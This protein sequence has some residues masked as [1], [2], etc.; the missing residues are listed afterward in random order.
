MPKKVMD[1][2]NTHFYKIVCKDLNIKNCYV[3][4][5]SNFIKRKWA[6][7]ETC[8]NENSPAYNLNIYRFIRD[9]GGFQNFDMILIDTVNCENR[10][11]A[12]K[13]EREYIESL[14][15]TL[16]R[17][18]PYISDEERIDR[19]K[20]N[21]QIYQAKEYQCECGQTV[22]LPEKSKH[23][24]TAKHLRLMREMNEPEYDYKK[25]IDEKRKEY[26]KNY[27]QENID[28]IKPKR[29]IYR[30]THKEEIALLNKQYREKNNDKIL[31]YRKGYYENK[32]DYVIQRVKQYRKNNKDKVQEK[33]RQHRENNKDLYYEKGRKYREKNS[34]EIN[35]ECG[36][37]IKKYNL[38][39][40]IKSQKHQDYLKSLQPEETPEIID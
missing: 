5:T 13:K 8:Y 40:H 2:S 29:Q 1:Y 39:C 15:A 9:N 10:L 11:E 7:K 22:S 18:T 24:K 36:K 16:N 4:H 37:V 26:R 31:D 25:E 6:H 38:N 21:R 3:G 33:S 20:K 23:I 34:Y 32:K 14:N 17:L 30:D 19:D 28:T 27:Y 35:C 12:C